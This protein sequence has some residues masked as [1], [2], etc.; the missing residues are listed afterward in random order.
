MQRG[1]PTRGRGSTVP[2]DAHAALKA[3]SR[4]P[5]HSCVHNRRATTAARGAR[6]AHMHGRPVIPQY[7]AAP[8]RSCSG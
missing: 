6:T 4:S 7:A 1:R 3:L 8:P 2:T 5:L